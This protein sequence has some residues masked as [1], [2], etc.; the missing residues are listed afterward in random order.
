MLSAQAAKFPTQFT[1]TLAAAAASYAGAEA[2]AGQGSTEYRQLACPG[3]VGAPAV[4][5][6]DQR[7]RYRS[8]RRARRVVDRQRRLRWFRRARPKRR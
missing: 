4:R 1:Q 7:G 5:Q 8:R 6:R 3:L 2:D